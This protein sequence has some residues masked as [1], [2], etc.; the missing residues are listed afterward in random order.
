MRSCAF[1]IKEYCGLVH[2]VFNERS[3][4]CLGYLSTAAT[5]CHSTMYLPG[6]S[7]DSLVGG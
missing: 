2:A 5:K 6:V 3:S 4:R 1:S 7:V